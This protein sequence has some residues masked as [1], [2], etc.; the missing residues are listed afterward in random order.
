MREEDA[1][2]IR[3]ETRKWRATF[4]ADFYLKTKAG[5]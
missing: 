1:Q 2:L 3:L 4:L 5:L